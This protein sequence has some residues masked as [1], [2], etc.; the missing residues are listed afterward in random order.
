MFDKLSLVDKALVE[1]FAVLLI[2]ILLLLLL[3]LSN[4]LASLWIPLLLLFLVIRPNNKEVETLV[5][6]H[7]NMEAVAYNKEE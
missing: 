6:N 7:H 2:L 4:L 3:F 1:L 5:G